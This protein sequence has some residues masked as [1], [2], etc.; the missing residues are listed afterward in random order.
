M[1]PT[2]G[3]LDDDPA[4]FAVVLAVLVVVFLALVSAWYALVDLH[5]TPVPVRPPTPAA[6]PP[7]QGPGCLAEAATELG[8][9]VVLCGATYLVAVGLQSR[10]ALTVGIVVLLVATGIVVVLLRRRRARA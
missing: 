9:P 4:A 1:W 8:I 5:P 10:P 2:A 7:P 6:E 3:L